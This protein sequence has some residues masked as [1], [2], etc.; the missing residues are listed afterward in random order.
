MDDRGGCWWPSMGRAPWPPVS[1]SSW[2]P[3]FRRRRRH[4]L[5]V[6]RRPRRRWTGV[7]GG[8]DGVAAGNPRPRPRRPA[9]RQ[10]AGR[11][12]DAG[13]R[14]SV[15]CTSPTAWRACPSC[16]VP[17][18]PRSSPSAGSS[19]LV[20]RSSSQS[21]SRRCRRALWLDFSSRT[22]VTASRWNSGP[23][24]RRATPRPLPVGH[25]P[26]PPT[27][28]LPNGGWSGPSRVQFAA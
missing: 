4:R 6:L 25:V 9:A 28:R 14:R 21:R 18:A 10:C 1:R 2:P 13:R 17:L 7:D 24:L 27:R 26:P 23:V 19:S 16:T 8:V 12:D 22:I 5:L 20:E 11:C 3:T 15:S